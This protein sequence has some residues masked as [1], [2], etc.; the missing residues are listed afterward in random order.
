MNKKGAIE[1][2][3]E[4][5]KYV[6]MDDIRLA[7]EVYGSGEISVLCFH[8]NGKNAKDFKFLETPQRKIISVHL[9]L[10]EYST[11]D[12]SRINEDLITAQHIQHLITMILDRENVNEFHWVAYSQ[13]GRFTLSAL[14]YFAER[15]RSMFLIA[16]DGMNDN[17]FYSWSQRQWWTRKL[18]HRWVNKPEELMSIS[19]VL[20]KGRIIHPKIVDFLDFYTSDQDKFETAYE[21]WCAFRKIRP[22]LEVIKNT[23]K[24]HDID[25]NLINGKYD[26][27]ISLK[28]AIDFLQEIDQSSALI[29]LPYGHDVFKPHIIEELF[30]IMKFEKFH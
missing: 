2:Q 26:Q 12:E 14:P 11:F 3:N 13:G 27:I 20:A 18:F 1:K 7:Y 19:K 29:E 25:F 10:H 15:V 23:L 16:P 30:E 22:S 24:K 8:G 5:I 21:T 17:N 6:E 28:S 4:T 9:F